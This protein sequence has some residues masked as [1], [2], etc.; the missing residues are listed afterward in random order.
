MKE[1]G[2]DSWVYIKIR[3]MAQNFI[4]LCYIFSNIYNIVLYA[5]TF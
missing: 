2:Q 4:L 5:G 1:R 3:H